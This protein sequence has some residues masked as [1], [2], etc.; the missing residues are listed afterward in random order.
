MKGIILAGGTGTRLYPMTVSV[1][2]QILPIYDKPMIYYP[3]SVLMLARIREILI[4]ST[5]RDLPF[6]ESLFGDG[7]SLGLSITYA[8]QEKPNGIAEAFLIGEDFIGKDRVAL[9][10]GDNFFHGYGFT[11]RLLSAS[12]RD[13][14]TIFGYH[15]SHPEAFGVVEFDDEMSVISIEEKP[16]HPKSN[17]VV[18]GLYFYDSD[19]V[20]IAKLIKPSDRGELEIT[21]I[22]QVYLSQGRLKVE[23]LGRGM[24][25]LDTGTPSGLLEAANYVQAIQSRQG[26]YVGCLEE[27]AFKQGYISRDQLVE[28]IQPLRKTAY[29]EYLLNLLAEME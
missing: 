9:I 11:K 5:K 29:G 17:Y 14:A 6:Y 15:V 2:K 4:I 1:S 18:P 25:W 20:D 12:E 28:L 19:V 21:S 16:Q 22:N 7:G 8:L 23:L 26:L 10:L 27:I 3:L 24:A 13:G